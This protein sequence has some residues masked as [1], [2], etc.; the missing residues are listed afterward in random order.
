MKYLDSSATKLQINGYLERYE[1][2]K[3]PNIYIY[4]TKLQPDLHIINSY[5]NK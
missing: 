4:I 2:L 1:I 3:N 5:K